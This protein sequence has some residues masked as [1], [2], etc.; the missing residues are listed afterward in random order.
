LADPSPTPTSPS[1]EKALE[2]A[3]VIADAALDRNAREL[4]AFDIA[5]LTSYADV[6]FV[7]TG[8]SDRQVRAIADSI[9]ERLRARGEAPLGIE[10]AESGR[11]IL[12]DCDDVVVHVFDPETRAT[13][14][15]E[16]LWSDAPRL[17]L[18]VPEDAQYDPEVHTEAL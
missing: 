2:K 17:D 16:R 15:L 1:L 5:E 3:R 11:W 18:Q 8:G 10:G 6:L 7:A 13:Y 12:L 9:D 14:A 4:L